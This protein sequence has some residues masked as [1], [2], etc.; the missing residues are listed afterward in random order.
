VQE[1]GNLKR[2]ENLGWSTPFISN[3]VGK[4]QPES[5]RRY[6]AEANERDCQKYQSQDEEFSDLNQCLINA[7]QKGAR[8]E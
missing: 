1:V 8:L 6:L 4:C 7:L 2:T 5:L 3:F